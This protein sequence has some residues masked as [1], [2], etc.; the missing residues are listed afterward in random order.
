VTSLY[1]AG[2]WVALRLAQS[3][4]CRFALLVDGSPS[5]GSHV[6]HDGSFSDNKHAGAG[7][8]AALLETNGIEVFDDDQIDA[9]AVRLAAE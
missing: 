1:V 3:R 6:T 8:A 5:C 4:G 2:A 9:L 7:V